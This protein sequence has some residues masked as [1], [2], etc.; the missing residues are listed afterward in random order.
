MNDAILTGQYFWAL[1][2]GFFV[3]RNP[4]FS[5]RIT[6]F[7]RLVELSGPITKKKD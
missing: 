6:K 4:R 5:Y 3:F 2:Y 7:I 1:L